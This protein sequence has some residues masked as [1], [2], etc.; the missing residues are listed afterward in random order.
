MKNYNSQKGFTLIEMI[1][2][3]AI[4]GILA[5]VVAPRV[6]E[7]IRDAKVTSAIA[8]VNSAKSAALNY[9]ARYDTFPTDISLTAQNDDG[10]LARPVLNYRDSTDLS[11]PDPYEPSGTQSLDFGDI[12]VYESQMLEA[13]D[14]PIG[15]QTPDNYYAVGC[16]QVNAAGVAD[17]SAGGD[18]QAY[19]NTWKF[20]SAGKATRVVYFYFPNLTAQEAAS[21]GVK[22]N[23]PYAS[24]I[25]G[26]EQIIAQS[27]VSAPIASNPVNNCWFTSNVDGTYDAYLYVAHQ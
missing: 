3:L 24:N 26:D 9:Y 16:S 4:I 25:A 8:S 2:V 27:I 10:D 23:G 20:K 1:G 17:F 22:V 7:S 19:G 18:S 6:I 11:N 21:L 13:E 5:A 14:V 12:L 15:L